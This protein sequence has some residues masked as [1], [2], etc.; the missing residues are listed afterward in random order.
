MIRKNQ[1]L[2]T[3]KNISSQKIVIHWNDSLIV[4]PDETTHKIFFVNSEEHINAKENMHAGNQRSSVL[5]SHM[6]LNGIIGNADNFIHIPASYTSGY[7][8]CAGK[9][10]YS[11]PGYFQ[12]EQCFYKGIVERNTENSIEEETSMK[13]NKVYKIALT[14]EHDNK[15][16]DYT[17]ALQITEIVERQ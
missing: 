14:V 7:V 1:I 11:I 6:T 2:L 9:S 17:M 5:L 13:L 15:K 8:S 12:P 16:L 3:L 4:N 10:C